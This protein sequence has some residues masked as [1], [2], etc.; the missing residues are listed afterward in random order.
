MSASSCNVMLLFMPLFTLIF[1]QD[2]VVKSATGVGWQCKVCDCV[3]KDSLTYLDHIN[4]KKHQRH[5]GYT[6]RAEKSAVSDVTSKLLQLAQEKESKKK[7]AQQLADRHDVL[8]NNSDNNENDSSSSGPAVLSRRERIKA[9]ENDILKRQNEKD[10]KKRE[11]QNQA[12]EEEEEEDE[13]QMDPEM[14]AMMGFTSFGG[15][16]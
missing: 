8:E 14:A 16:K 13:P 7:R 4:G 3:L 6:M 5:L 15:A 1:L 2:G 12:E 11:Q 10:L 9:K